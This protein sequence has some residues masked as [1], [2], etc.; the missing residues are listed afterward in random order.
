VNWTNRKSIAPLVESIEEFI[1][2]GQ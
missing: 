1:K 2:K